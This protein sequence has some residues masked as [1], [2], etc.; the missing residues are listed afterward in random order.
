MDRCAAPGL[1]F[2]RGDSGKPTTLH[3]VAALDCISKAAG[4]LVE[5]KVCVKLRP[6]K[7]FQR[8]RVRGYSG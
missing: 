2:G 8:V 1:A 5:K 7:S 3:T 6:A 4:W